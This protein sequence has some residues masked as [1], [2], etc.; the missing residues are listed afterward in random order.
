MNIFLKPTFKIALENS[1]QR[2]QYVKL[3]ILKTKF[4]SKRNPSAK[5]EIS[6]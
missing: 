1:P 5:Y 4:L 3:G 6:D 2:W